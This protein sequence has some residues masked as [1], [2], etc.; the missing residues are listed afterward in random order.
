MVRRR[1]REV[2]GTPLLREHAGKTCIKGSNP[3]VSASKRTIKRLSG[4]FFVFGLVRQ[5]DRLHA[6][7]VAAFFGGAQLLDPV[8][9]FRG[10]RAV[11]MRLGAEQAQRR[12]GAGIAGAGA[13][14]V[15]GIAGRD[16]DGDAGVDAAVGAFD[17]VEEPGFASHG[18]RGGPA[19]GGCVRWCLPGGPCAIP[20]ARG[21]GRW[22]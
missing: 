16:V 15:R 13:G 3:F 12:V 7:G 2:E 10:R 22:H 6:V 11:G 20:P 5:V 19:P 18:G 1:G 9:G 14:A 21:C 17:Q 8:F 4:R